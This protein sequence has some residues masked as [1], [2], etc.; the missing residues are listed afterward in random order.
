MF[1]RKTLTRTVLLHPRFFARDLKKRLKVNLV[2]D[3]SGSCLGT[4][5]YVVAEFLPA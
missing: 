1:Y 3:V 5:G 2:K 4:D